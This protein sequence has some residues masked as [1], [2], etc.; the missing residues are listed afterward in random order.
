MKE[1]G[2]GISNGKFGKILALTATPFELEPREMVRLLALVRAKAGDLHLIECGLD[3]YVKH[4]AHF[5]VNFRQ[6]CVK[7][8]AGNC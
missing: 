5:F 3:L 7:G 4:L 6:A 8:T 2:Q 1:Y